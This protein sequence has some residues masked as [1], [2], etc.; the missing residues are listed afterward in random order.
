MEVLEIQM[1]KQAD[2]F[3]L[4]TMMCVHL[5]LLNFICSSMLV[6]KVLVSFNFGYAFDFIFHFLRVSFLLYA[7][8][9][10]VEYCILKYVIEFVWKRIPPI[11]HEFTPFYVNV[12][13]TFLSL[14]LGVVE[15]VS[16]FELDMSEHEKLFGPIS[17]R[18]EMNI[19]NT[20]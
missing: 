5:V 10:W 2:N 20:R 16:S 17:Y 3:Q 7:N 18:K 14:V 1:I 9:V 6:F 15:I 19:K 12:T 4:F 11:D 8:I 13:N